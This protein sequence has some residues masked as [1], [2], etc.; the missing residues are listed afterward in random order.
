MYYFGLLHNLVLA[1]ARP[2]VSEKSF[3]IPF[4]L[5]G[6]DNP[7]LVFLLIGLMGVIALNVL[8]YIAYQLYK[9]MKF[10]KIC[11]KVGLIGDEIGA[12]RSFIARFHYPN[13][14]F[15]L[16]RK[17]YFDGF[18]NQVAH[19]VY[20]S[21]AAEKEIFVESQ[22][23]AK[24]REKLG[25]S[26]SYGEKKLIS[27]R[28]LLKNFPLQ[29]HFRDN[30]LDYTFTFQ[31][32]I[33]ENY[34]FFLVIEPPDDEDMRKFILRKPKAPLDVQFIRENDSEYFFNSYLVRSSSIYEQKWVIQHSAQLLKGDSQKAIHINLSILCGGFKEFDVKECIG[35]IVLLTK[36]EI[37]FLIEGDEGENVK[38]A[39]GDTVLMAF[40]LLGTPVNF[41]GTIE[42]ITDRGGKDH[43]KMPLKGLSEDSQLLITKFLYQKKAEE[44]KKE[45]EASN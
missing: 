42:S 4:K 34:E 16:V 38:L 37:S 7:L 1:L 10:T 39:K 15:L 8:F 35:K 5:S 29:V 2:A 40:D 11:N 25:F 23:F 28:A 17:S 12:L 6:G 32:K 26:H 9:A 20:T 41:Q 36:K 31:A 27:S 18:M 33:I 22:F 14:I 30:N 44:E 24:I 43:F 21:K 19:V 3:K 45:P 13:P